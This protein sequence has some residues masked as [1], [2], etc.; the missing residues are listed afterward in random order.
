M[1]VRRRAAVGM[2]AVAV[3]VVATGGALWGTG[4]VPIGPSGGGGQ[5]R[6]LP[7]APLSPRADALSVWTGSELVVVG[8]DRRPCPPTADCA[9]P[10]HLARD[11]AAYDPT[12][13]QWHPIADAPVGAGPGDRLVTADG[14]VV[15]RHV[16][17]DGQVQY[18][19]YDPDGDSWTSIGRPGL[20][21]QRDHDLPSALGSQV[22]VVVG[23]RVWVFISRAGPGGSYRSTRCSRGWPSPG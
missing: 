11:G 9:V 19:V 6:E 23:R 20:V 14:S 3:L 8:G 1:L 16:F 13:D 17:A 12:T 15:L 22:F 7:A 10:S 4:R 2:A 21:W 5:W 18:Y